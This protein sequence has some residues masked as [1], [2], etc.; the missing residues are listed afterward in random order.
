MVITLTRELEAVLQELARQRGIDP[1]VL[2]LDALRD[3]FS[4]MKQAAEPNDD[5][6]RSVIQAAT[7][8]GVSLPHQALGSEGLYE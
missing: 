4:F 6:E 1:E 3:R 8:C 5:W 2:A 7:D